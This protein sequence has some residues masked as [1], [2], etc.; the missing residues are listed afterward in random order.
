MASVSPVQI[1]KPF[2]NK[3]LIITGVDNAVQFTIVK[4]NGDHVTANAHKNQDLFWALRGGGAGSWGVVTSVTY[5]TY[6]LVPLV[7]SV[8]N[9]TFPNPEA[10]QTITT[11]F[12]KLHPKLS[13]AHWGGYSFFS[14]SSLLALFLAP[15]VSWADTNTTILPF[16]NMALNVTQDP[17]ALAI[18]VPF[19]NF[20]AWTNATFGAGGGADQV[21]GVVELASRLISREAAENRPEDT[22]QILLSFEFVAIKY[23]ILDRMGNK[24]ILILYQLR[25][26]WCRSQC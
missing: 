6:D 21:G 19:D 12:I 9:V 26:R 23:V 22:A 18:T 3:T 14:N 16:F 15:N 4:S 11:E 20:Y 13:D 5:K 1:S 17:N 2:I 8:L 7:M 24:L 10:A 25:C